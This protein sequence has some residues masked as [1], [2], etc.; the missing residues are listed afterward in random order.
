MTANRVFWLAFACSLM[1][2]SVASADALRIRADEW[3]PFNCRSGDQMPGYVIE[4]AEQIFGEA[5][6]GVDYRILGWARSLKQARTGRVEA[7]VGAI[8]EEVEGFALSAPVGADSQAYAVRK[9]TRID[10]GAA[11]PFGSMAVGIIRDYEYYEP[12]ASLIEQ[13]GQNRFRVQQAT[14]DDPLDSNLKKLRHR[15]L[16]VV[17]DNAIVLQYRIKALGLD[18]ELEILP[19]TPP[20]PLFLAF[21]PAIDNADELASIFNAGVERYRADGR[22]AVILRRYG[23]ADW[24]N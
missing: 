22:L 12:V 10:W 19:G 2:S 11:D 4:L 13:H 16:D 5:G 20:E 15:R 23:V 18:D 9:G 1:T 21:S 6:I 24:S 17:V 7:V 8:A 14:G 3:C